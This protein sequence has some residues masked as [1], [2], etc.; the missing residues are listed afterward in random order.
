M[1]QIKLRAW[2]IKKKGWKGLW[3]FRGGHTSEYD[4]SNDKIDVLDLTDKWD[5]CILMQYTGLK[6][7]NGVE[8][9]EGDRWQHVAGGFIGIVEFVNSQW[10]FTNA[11]D[12]PCISYPY[13]HSNAEKGEVIGN[14]HENPELLKAPFK[15]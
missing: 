7:K 1:R 10:Q 9:Y 11:Y 12:S 14:I 6:D 3:I 5:G 8:I 2:H 13:F 15:R 4:V